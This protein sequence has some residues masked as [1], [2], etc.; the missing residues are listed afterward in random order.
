[1]KVFLFC[2]LHPVR[3]IDREALA[4][5][6]ALDTS[7]FDVT[8]HY[9]A[10]GNVPATGD[11]YDA[12]TAK[13]Q[14]A[15]RLFLAGDYDAMLTVEY[16][17]IVPVDALQKLSRVDADVAY[18]LY[19]ARHNSRWLAFIKIWDSSGIT[20]S[21]DEATTKA[22][23]GKVI[24][25]VGVGFG[26]TLIHRHVLE[27]I[28]FRRVAGHPCCN[29]WFFALDCI[30][31]G[32]RQKHD[33]SVLVGHVRNDAP[34]V[35]IWPIAEAPFHR[36]EEEN[37]R[38]L[39]TLDMDSSGLTEYVCNCSIVSQS[40]NHYYQPGDSI[41]L[42]AESAKVHLELGQ[43]SP[44]PVAIEEA[45]KQRRKRELNNPETEE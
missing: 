32:Y 24:D 36:L 3:S 18:G 29:D 17:N 21:L 10:E 11:A 27:A 2:P 34:R 15:Q 43:V 39:A 30:A 22:A 13:Y 44:K 16:D 25:S 14:H 4:A 5:I 26:C 23:W 20:Y 28:P 6:N 45:P 41:W 42:T 37:R 31:A 1:V 35:V 8:V 40:Q 9:E 12:V 33:T 38:E 19:C 7:G